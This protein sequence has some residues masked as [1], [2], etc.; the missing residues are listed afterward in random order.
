MSVICETH[1]LHS[2]QVLSLFTQD[3]EQCVHCTGFT[4]Q[5]FLWSCLG[6]VVFVCVPLVFGFACGKP[7]LLLFAGTD[8]PHF[9]VI[10]GRSNISVDV[11]GVDV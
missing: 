4:K 3:R 6:L 8:W 1:S 11:W 10:W 5:Y 9:S 2:V 7:E